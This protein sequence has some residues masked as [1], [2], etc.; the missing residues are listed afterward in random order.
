MADYYETLGVQR[1]ATDADLKSAYRKLAMQYHPDRNPDNADAEQKF[2]E[3]SGA[4]EVLKDGDSR[5]AY[6]RMGHDAFNQRRSGGGGA[7]AGAGGFDFNFTSSFSDIFDEVF[8][9][10]GRR[11]GGQRGQRGADLRYNMEI[12]L[13]EA[14]AGKRAEIRVPTLGACESCHGS[15]A[16]DGSVPTGCSTCH[17]S[18][19]VR[20]SQGFFTVERTCPNC[21]GQ[22]QVI[23]DPCKACGG[24]GRVRRERT[25]QVNIPPGVDDGTRIRLSGEGEA[26][27][28]GA[29]GG[30]LYIFIGIRQHELFERDSADIYCRAPIPMTTAA[31]GGQI[32]CPSVD[33]SRARITIPMGTQSGRR[34][35]LRGKG[36]SILNQRGRGDMYI[37]AHIETPVNLTKRQEEI[38]KEFEEE[39]EGRNN[40]PEAEGF[41]SKVKDFWDDLRD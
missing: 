19:R 39:S 20:A 33:G 32:E 30:D 18:G 29:P 7:G 37:E 11:G 36:M 23:S 5:A 22:G 15:G 21:Q 31:L 38:L 6:D 28:R 14:Y 16:E 17:G 9:E 24:Q 25:L 34:F 35:R 3:I 40:N 2:K 41:F 10:M 1:G 12:T 26:G 4:Y 27:M 13:E 8:G